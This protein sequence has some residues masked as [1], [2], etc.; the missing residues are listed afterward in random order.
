MDSDKLVHLTHRTRAPNKMNRK[1][2]QMNLPCLIFD[3]IKSQSRTANSNVNWLNCKSGNYEKY[4]F[5]SW[6]CLISS[7]SRDRDFNHWIE[8]VMQ[9]TAKLLRRW[10]MRNRLEPLAKSTLDI[11]LRAFWFKDLLMVQQQRRKVATLDLYHKKKEE[12]K[13]KDINTHVNYH[14]GRSKWCTIREDAHLGLAQ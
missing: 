13:Q 14:L 12:S 10:R 2:N 8:E 11:S 6:L 3:Q 4:R 9:T 5:G 7:L 1:A